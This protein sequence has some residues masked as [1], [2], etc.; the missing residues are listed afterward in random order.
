M[1]T[2]AMAT[3]GSCGLLRGDCAL[4]RVRADRKAMVYEPDP[5]SWCRTCRKASR[6]KCQLVPV[7]PVPKFKAGDVVQTRFVVPI[8]TPVFGRRKTLYLLPG[9]AWTVAAVETFETAKP[10]YTLK[11][12]GV[13][14]EI[15]RPEWML[16][17]V[18]AK[19]AKKPRPE[20]PVP[21][22]F[23]GVG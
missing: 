20:S 15:E 23:A 9:T 6:G 11:T 19:A 4:V 12:N 3:C 2:E 16:T 14:K 18:P 22:L 17:K 5:K 7:P 8:R 13:H 21:A 10:R 1:A